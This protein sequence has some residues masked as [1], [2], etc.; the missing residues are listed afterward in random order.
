M[1][2]FRDIL[3]L[4]GVWMSRTE[5]ITID[6]SRYTSLRCAHGVDAQLL[7]TDGLIVDLR[8]ATNMDAQLRGK[9]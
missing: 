1:P 5:I 6:P 7:G 3:E 9:I 4:C 2:G 8:S